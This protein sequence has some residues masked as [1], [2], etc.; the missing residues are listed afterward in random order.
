M[1]NKTVFE[2]LLPQGVWYGCNGQ[3]EWREKHAHF[4]RFFPRVRHSKAES[5]VLFFG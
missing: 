5:H 4:K 2:V 3:V 1:G